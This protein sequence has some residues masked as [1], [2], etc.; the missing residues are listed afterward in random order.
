[1]RIKVHFAASQFPRGP[2]RPKT[3]TPKSLSGPLSSHLQPKSNIASTSPRSPLPIAIRS[4]R[5]KSQSHCETTRATDHP[6][7]VAITI[8]PI[9]RP[10]TPRPKVS[11]GTINTQDIHDGDKGFGVKI[12]EEF[13]CPLPPIINI[14]TK[15]TNKLHYPKFTGKHTKFSEINPE[16]PT[17]SESLLLLP[18]SQLNIPS[19]QGLIPH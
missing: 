14:P 16:P 15:T 4:P 8:P 17:T 6:P 5:R 2:I 3:A 11:N 18:V 13:Y 7:I 12:P 19:M 1:V 10:S 9:P